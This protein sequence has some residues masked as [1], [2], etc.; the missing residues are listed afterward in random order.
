MLGLFIVPT[1]P[2][3]LADVD[4]DDDDDGGGEDGD[5]LLLMTYVCIDHIT[6]KLAIVAEDYELLVT[7]VSFYDCTIHS[8]YVHHLYF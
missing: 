2:S 6:M 3:L 4:N 1:V 8:S 7:S 5:N